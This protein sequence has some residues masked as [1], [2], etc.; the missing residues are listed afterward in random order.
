MPKLLQI[1]AIIFRI[2]NYTSEEMTDVY[3]IR[4]LE[5]GNRNFT[6][7]LYVKPGTVVIQDTS[8]HQVKIKK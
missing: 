6:R 4:E 7:C 3:F 8:E 2:V 5:I 1:S